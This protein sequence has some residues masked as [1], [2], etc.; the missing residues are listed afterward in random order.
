MLCHITRSG[1]MGVVSLALRTVLLVRDY[2]SSC[3]RKF[4]GE[5]SDLRDFKCATS[6]K[7]G[8]VKAKC[9]I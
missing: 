3:S 7:K 6:V 4:E 8:H 2:L 5:V 9:F 1:T